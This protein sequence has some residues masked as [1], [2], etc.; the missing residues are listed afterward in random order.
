MKSPA[1][2]LATLLFFFSISQSTYGGN[3]DQD[4]KPRFQATRVER[5]VQL[6]GKLD[7]PLWKLGQPVNLSYEISPGEN[8]RAPQITFATALYTNDYLYIGFRC[9]D[10]DPGVIRANMTD[11]DRIFQDDFVMAI[12]DTYGDFQRGY[13]FAVNPFGIQADLMKTLNNEDESFDLVWHSAAARN[14]SGWTAELAIPFKSLRFPNVGEQKWSVL[15]YRV[16]PRT[17][18]VIISWTQYDRNNPS[19]LSQAGLLTGLADIESGGSFELLPYAMGQQTGSLVNASDPKSGFSNNKIQG[20]VG[21]GIQY[22]PSP[23]FTL[24]AVLNPDFSQIETDADQ[25]SVNTTFALYYQE[26]R[27]FF[28]TGQELLQTPMY[29]SR[30]INNPL[31]AARING[32]SGGVSYMYLGAYDRN[33]PFDVPGEEG[34]NTFSSS[35]KSFSNIGRVRYDLGNETYIGSMLM[36]RNFSDGHNYLLGFDWNY[37]F[38]GNW[39]FSGEGF[40]SQTKELNDPGLFTSGRRFGDT[41]FTAGF[42]GERYSGSGLHLV[43]SHSSREYNLNIVINNF[44]PTYQTYNGLFSSVDYRAIGIYQGYT[45]YPNNSILDRARIQLSANIQYNYEGVKKEQ[46]VQPSLCLQF[47]GQTHVDAMYH[48]V[49]DE[50]FRNVQFN[51]VRRFSV[52]MNSRPWRE[53]S[54]ELEAQLGR[55]IYRSSTPDL[56]TGHRLGAT[57]TIRPTTKLK[58]DLAY[59]RARLSSIATDRLYFDGNIVRTVATYQFTTEAFLR[60]IAQYNSF[61]KSFSV[62]PLFSYKLNAF[63]TFYAG[64]TNDYLDYGSDTGFATTARQ[65]FV[66]LQYLLRN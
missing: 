58:L 33:T 7:D 42:D 56:G 2:F 12:L 27:P 43:L 64:I 62:Y 31:G 1:I 15:L 10:S 11:R 17:S 19:D 55:F 14:D 49:N 60:G 45:I 26:K 16:Y 46:N 61:D 41:E 29:Y 5:S 30:S 3:G 23:S 53:L 38:W 63:T 40:L 34:S 59:S 8:V 22:S 4:S 57:L 35:R 20:R 48:L 44:S 47:K 36:T 21:G 28:L 32:K 51:N 50:R 52:F 66:K 9:Y 37:K 24:D 13:E 25:I 39:Y 6:T 65:Y 18:R 54:L